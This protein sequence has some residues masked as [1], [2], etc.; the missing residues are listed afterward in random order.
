MGLARMSAMGAF[1]T[2]DASKVRQQQQQ[3]QQQHN[4]SSRGATPPKGYTV[5]CIRQHALI[6]TPFPYANAPSAYSLINI[7]F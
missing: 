1:A 5:T 3:Q 6:H 7:P 2:K 4:P